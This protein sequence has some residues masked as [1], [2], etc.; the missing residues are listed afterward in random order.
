MA[1][2]QLESHNPSSEALLKTYDEDSPPLVAK[3][4]AD[5]HRAWLEWSQLSVVERTKVL[6]PL[7]EELRVKKGELARLAADEMGKPLAQGIA[8]VEKCAWLCEHLAKTSENLLKDEQIPTEARSSYVTFRPLGVI[9]GVMPWNFPYW[10]VF[11]F[12]VPALAAGN[13]ALLKHASNVTGCSIAIENLFHKISP[14]IPLL[15]ALLLSSSKIAHVISD[16]VIQ[17]VALTGS[18]EA[19]KKVASAAGSHLKKTVLELGGSDP[20]LILEDADLEQAADT[21]TNSR[22]INSGQS[23]ISAKRFIVVES[24][25]ERFEKIFVEKMR[26]KSFGDPLDPQSA[27]GPLARADLRDELHRQVEQS[28]QAGAKLLLGGKIPANQKGYF[29]PPTVLS[30]IRKGMRVGDE[31]TFGPVAAVISAAD[32]EEAIRIANESPFGLGAAVFTKNLERGNR[33]AKLKLEAGNCFVNAFVK[34]DPRLPFGGIKESGYGRELGAFGIHEFVNIK[35][36]VV[37]A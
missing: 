25:R 28:L 14:R 13:I 6:N 18:T 2:S 16:P 3:K 23:C 31:E 1:K 33:I 24:V 8:E 17:G 26:S 32:E 12:A 30:G 10:Q 5:A 20:Y 34:S 15:Q 36:V 19:G 7:A 35:S 21:C 29:Y 9:L 22:L 37:Q 4:I 11:R 27:I